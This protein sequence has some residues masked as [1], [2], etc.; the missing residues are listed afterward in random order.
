MT[1]GT[2]SCEVLYTQAGDGSYNAAPSITQTRT[3]SRATLTVTPDA[4]TVTYGDA[5]P[6]YTFGVT[7]FVNSETALTAAG[8]V[9]PTCASNYTSTTGVVPPTRTISCSGGSA[10]NYSF[11][12]SAISNVTIQKKAAT[13]TTN[14]NGKIFGA[15]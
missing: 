2:G 5:A 13:W 8:Y 12:T 15:S 1:S 14:P 10:D 9:A 3:A 4:K 11:V 6:T 7:G